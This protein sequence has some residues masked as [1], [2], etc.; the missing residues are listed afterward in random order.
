M[1]PKGEAPGLAMA[2]GGVGVKLTD[3]TMLYAGIARG[4]MAVPLIERIDDAHR[5]S[6][7]AAAARSGRGLV[8]RQRADRHA[9]AGECRRRPHRLQDR[10]VLRLSRRLVGRLRRQAHHRRLGRAARRRAGAR[11]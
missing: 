7:A 9:A 2:L 11:A 6:A 5:A 4:G 3:L 1:L 10:H 8:C